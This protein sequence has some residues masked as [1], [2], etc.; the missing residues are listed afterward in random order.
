MSYIAKSTASFAVKTKDDD[1]DD[2]YEGDNGKDKHT[3]NYKV[4]VNTNECGGI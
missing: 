1:D 4:L 2:N 3:V